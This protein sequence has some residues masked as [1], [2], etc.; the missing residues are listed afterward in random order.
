MAMVGMF[1]DEPRIRPSDAARYRNP[2]VAAIHAS[3]ARAAYRNAE[4]A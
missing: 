2:G 1:P 4:H 3:L